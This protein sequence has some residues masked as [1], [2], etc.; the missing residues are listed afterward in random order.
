MFETFVGK[1]KQTEIFL[2]KKCLLHTYDM[3]LLAG[4]ET[5]T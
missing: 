4:Y 5:V 1:P 2:N 3:E